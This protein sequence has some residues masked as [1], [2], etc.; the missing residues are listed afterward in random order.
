MKNKNLI[1][2]KKYMTRKRI[3]EARKRMIIFGLTVCASIVILGNAHLT[4]KALAEK[5]V[6]EPV[7]IQKVETIPEMITRKAIENNVD[8]ETALRIANCESGFNPQAKNKTSSASGL[9]QFINSTWNNY[10]TGD[11]MNAEDNAQCF[12]ELYPSHPSWWICQ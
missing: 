11:R 5:S 9:Y 2:R 12:M 8:P 4:N 3:F 1:H 7:I 10:C 6:I